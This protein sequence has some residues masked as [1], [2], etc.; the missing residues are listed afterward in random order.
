MLLKIFNY[1]SN[2]NLHISVD[3]S[4]MY[5]KLLKDVFL[6]LLWY[7]ACSQIWLYLPMDHCHFGYFTKLTK[8]K[9]LLQN[10]VLENRS[11]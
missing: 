8:E 11:C 3:G 6:K 2:K 4:S 7:V 10:R 5:P 1:F 9:T